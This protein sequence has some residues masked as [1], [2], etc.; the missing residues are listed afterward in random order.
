MEE[1]PIPMKCYVVNGS[2][3]SL[4]ERPRPVP[5]EGECLVRV[6]IA[7][8]CNTDLEI[9]KGYMGFA[10]VVG[11][12]FVG[13]VESAP[14]GWDL[15]GKRVVGDINLCCHS[16]TCGTCSL[17]GDRARN[18]C[19]VRTVLGILNK[20]GTYAEYLTMPAGNLHIVPDTV[21]TENA[22][23]MEP[24]AAACRIIEQVPPAAPRVVHAPRRPSIPTPP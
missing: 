13:V 5:S 21:S 2:E 11:H 17:G 15:V 22:A 10:G 1:G 8:V 14:E 24:L 19:P 20:D 16:S 9:M 7:A 3:H 12:E 6:L 23:F 4:Q 18:H